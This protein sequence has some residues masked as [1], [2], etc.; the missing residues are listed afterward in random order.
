MQRQCTG[1]ENTLKN[2]TCHTLNYSLQ[3]IYFPSTLLANWLLAWYFLKLVSA[4]TALAFLASCQVWS[5]TF[6]LFSYYLSQWLSC[7][8]CSNVLT[9][10][11][12]HPC[13]FHVFVVF[14][15]CF[16]MTYVHCLC[17]HCVL[18]LWCLDKNWQA[19]V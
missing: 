18:A 7:C 13:L 6:H 4:Y 3:S 17:R 15:M 9:K 16:L 8:N 1:G 10:A 12:P 14:H 19:A 5:F 2:Q 11:M